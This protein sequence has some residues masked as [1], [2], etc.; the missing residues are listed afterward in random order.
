MADLTTVPR[1]CRDGSTGSP[2]RRACTPVPSDFGPGDVGDDEALEVMNVQALV[3][4]V[5][6]ER[7]EGH[8][9]GRHLAAL[10]RLYGRRR[11]DQVEDAERALPEALRQIFPPGRQ[12]DVRRRVE[13]LVARRASRSLDPPAAPA[14][15]AEQELAERQRRQPRRFR[16][17][18]PGAETHPAGPGRFGRRH[19][20]GP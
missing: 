17:E 1:G 18:D 16:A 4:P 5:H 8:A 7:L 19:L 14:Q 9:P 6:Q 10:E 15:V 3:E 12:A 11:H 13:V 20:V 2:R